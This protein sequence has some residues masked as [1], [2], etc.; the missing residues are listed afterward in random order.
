M[1][2]ETLLNQLAETGL[3]GILLVLALI[4]IAFLYRENKKEREDRLSDLQEF[5][6]TDR[7]FINEMKQTLENILALLRGQK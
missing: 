3:M 5:S 4:V 2:E 6:K 1:I 7:T